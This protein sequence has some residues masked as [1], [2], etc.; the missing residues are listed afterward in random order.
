MAPAV[1]PMRHRGEAS[2]AVI[3]SGGFSLVELL[4]AMAVVGILLGAVY[5]TFINF[6]SE[7]GEQAALS[8]RSFDTRLGLQLLRSD[9]RQVGFG[10]ADGQLAQTVS[11]SGTSLTFRSTAVHSRGSEA[12]IH[13][14]LYTGAGGNLQANNWLGGTI[15]ATTSGIV[16]TPSRERLALAQLQ[17][18]TVSPRNLFFST[19]STTVTGYYYQRTYYLGGGGTAAGCADNNVQNLLFR[20]ANPNPYPGTSIVDCVLDIR[21][22]YGYEMSD[23]AVSYSSDTINPP[24][25]TTADDL[26]DTVKVGLIAQVGH[27][28]RNKKPSPAT[29]NFLDG[30]LKLADPIDLSDQQRRYR[31]QRL[32]W[33]IP[34]ENMP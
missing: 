2:G 26:P 6:L 28:Y 31:W 12:G 16:L 7:S 17:N 30:D 14:V 29:L 10:I 5:G 11:G 13:G 23:G 15:A 24:A 25:G 8:K 33:T 19:P 3:L 9:L 32:E 20:D 34:L 27:E 18:V 22:R 21:F 4:V 1:T